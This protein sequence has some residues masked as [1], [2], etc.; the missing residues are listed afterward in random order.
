MWNQKAIGYRQVSLLEA[1]HVHNWSCP[2][3][4]F[5]QQGRYCTSE[6]DA[7]SCEATKAVAKKA[8]ENF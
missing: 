4:T 8:L 6:S 1:L 3:Q 5:I 2:I 7:H